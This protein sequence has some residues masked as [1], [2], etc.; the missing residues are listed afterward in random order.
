MEKLENLILENNKLIA[1]FMGY[2][3]CSDG[4]IIGK[5]GKSLKLYTGSSNYLQANLYSKGSSKTFLLHRLLAICFI[6]NPEN[7][8]EVNHIDGDKLNN[9]LSNL[10]W[11]SRSENINHG[12][13]NGLIPSPWKDKKGKDHTRSKITLQINS[14]NEIV[15]EFG[16]AR[17][18]SR[19]TGINYGTIS[20]V[21]IGRG[22]TAGGFKWKYK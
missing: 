15:N 21:L 16:S 9:E 5:Y 19:I 6:P 18:A 12:I 8:P 20:N 13:N 14:D 17:E 22:K 2:K 4:V 7:K 1:E 10:E 11:V 3:I